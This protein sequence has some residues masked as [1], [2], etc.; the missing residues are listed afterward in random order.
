MYC[1]N[2]QIHIDGGK[3]CPNCGGRL[4]PDRIS[5]EPSEH[6]DQMDDNSPNKKEKRSKLFPVLI[7][8]AVVVLL[9]IVAEVL[10]FGLFSNKCVVTFDPNDGNAAIEVVVNKG[11]YLTTPPVPERDGYLLAGWFTDKDADAGEAFDFAKTPVEKSMTL[12]G[13]W[14]EGDEDS[15]AILY[16]ISQL[17]IIYQQ[18]DSADYVTRDLVLPTTVEGARNVRVTWTSSSDTITS[19]GV[20]TRPT[21][22]D[23]IVR[24]TLTVKKNDAVIK[25]EYDLRVIHISENRNSD[26]PNSSVIDIENMNEGEYFDVSYNGDMTQIISIDGKFSE[27]EIDNADDALDAIQSIHTIVGLRDPYNEL[28][29]IA[30]NVDEYGAE[31]A[32]Q[33]YYLGYEVYG[34]RV[35]VSADSDG[36]T[37]SLSSGAYATY[38]LD[39]VDMTTS[40]TAEEACANAENYYS[41]DCSADID[42]TKLVFYTLFEYENSPVFAYAVPIS[43][44][45]SENEYK[46]ET[47][48]ISARD[49]NVLFSEDNFSPVSSELGCGTDELG[50]VVTFPVA[51]TWKDW[52]FF[53]MQDIDRD[54]CM[55]SEGLLFKHRV[56]S[57]F[58]LWRDGSAVSA[59]T[60]VI[61]TYDWYKRVLGR[62]SLDGN[63]F[64]IKVVVH[65]GSMTDNAFWSGNKKTLNFCD[66]SKGN[67]ATTTTACGLDIVAHE[68]THGIVQFV[69]GGLTYKNAPGAI[70]EGYADIFGCLIQ[71]DWKIGEDWIELRDAA[72]PT[73]HENPDKMS[74]PYYIDY[75]VNDS[76]NGGVH[77]NSAL[78]YHSAYLMERAGMDKTT[79]AKLWYKS[80][81]MGYDNSSDFNTVR[82]N[83]LKAAKKMDL[84]EQ[85]IQI[86][87]KAFD[88]VEIFG[89]RGT[90][91]VSVQDVNGT[92]LNDVTVRVLHNGTAVKSLRT[93]NNGIVS[94]L[95]DED[96]YRIEI[97]VKDYIKYTA[98]VKIKEKETTRVD[99]VLVKEGR[100]IVEGTVV[101]ATSAFTLSD[102]SLNIRSGLNVKT[103]DILWAGETGNEGRFRLE[104]D[105]GYYTIEMIRDGYTTG[106][107][108]V[109]VASG[110][111]SEANGSLSPIMSSTN[112]RVVL[113]WG[114]KPNDLDSHL[115]GTAQD[116]SNYHIYF[117]SKNAYN[118]SGERIANLDVDDTTSYGPETTTFTVD[119]EGTYYYY[120]HRYSSGN[121]PRSEAK[122]EVYNGY[123]L[124]ARYTINPNASDSNLYWD[125]FKIEKGIFQ[126]VD[127][128]R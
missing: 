85:Y 68:Y 61:T 114:A 119:T 82:R 113:T 88:K 89:D 50:K 59:Y 87:K 5:T 81:S 17:D 79:L 106:F 73:N 83:V 100:G 25:N 126:T 63:G 125:V 122:V 94:D 117:R 49:G 21:E 77:T 34:R 28:E 8:A 38:K 14:I 75:N 57:E 92:Y 45:N 60:N 121:F 2:C 13:R 12:Y 103:G 54:I 1:R 91:L 3:H 112:Y 19:E 32:F 10:V 110:L 22:Q 76:D 7:I 52:F 40:I 108:N 80:L 56:G 16:A 93:A 67:K 4:D 46:D 41:G 74:S 53:Y 48:F 123:N 18:G 70:N 20:V 23:E 101:S 102:V 15:I 96:I 35:T 95:F 9:M 44:V 42:T 109:V 55:Y 47:V 71:G 69:T 84:S 99:V 24:L 124:I 62:D 111:T 128:M 107:V 27:I 58:N 31:Y 26:I 64:D 11:E 78:L 39:Q 86:V 30:R 104:L 98:D 90:L 72:N 97:A 37:D 33:Q 118:R 43:G 115:V 116:G 66:N 105:A 127:A 120:V 29:I 65:E 51:Y 36:V 6:T